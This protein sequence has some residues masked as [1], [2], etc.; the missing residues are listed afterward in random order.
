MEHREGKPGSVSALVEVMCRNV[1]GSGFFQK[2]EQK[3]L[4]AN[5]IQNRDFLGL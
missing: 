3:N 2:Q 5:V 1:R 4:Q